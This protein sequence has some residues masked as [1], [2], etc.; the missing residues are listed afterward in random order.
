MATVATSVIGASAVS[1]IMGD[2]KANDSDA[3]WYDF[4]NNYFRFPDEYTDL[5][6]MML[7]KNPSRVKLG[8]TIVSSVTRTIPG[9]G[10]HFV[11]W[12]DTSWTEYITFHKKSTSS[13]GFPA[14]HYLCYSTNGQLKTFK[15]A[16]QLIFKTEADKIRTISIDASRPSGVFPLFVD[17][18]CGV[19]KPRQIIALNKIMEYWTE[20]HKFHCRVIICGFKGTGKTYTGRLLKNR[21]EAEDNDIMVRLYDDYNPTI[22]GA[23]YQMLLGQNAK[24]Y[25]PV[26]SVVDEVDICFAEA[27]KEKTDPGGGRHLCQS[28]TKDKK[29]LN[30]MLDAMSDTKYSMIIFT[31]EKSPEELYEHEDWHTFMRPGR[32]DFFLK[33]TGSTCTKVE[34]KDIAGYVEPPP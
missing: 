20:A 27:V 5:I 17:K 32:I 23:S 22:P 6:D 13:G 4:W 33:L 18:L 24:Q 1:Q 8:P 28:H 29:S 11:Y 26:V 12:K 3:S 14:Y 2:V 34:H 19:A 10:R 30:A 7:M 15:G 9:I 25:T 21:M 16:I 31:T